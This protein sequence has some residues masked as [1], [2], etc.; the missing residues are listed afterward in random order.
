MCKFIEFSEEISRETFHRLVRHVL[1][2]LMNQVYHEM[3]P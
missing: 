1:A 2:V 3:M